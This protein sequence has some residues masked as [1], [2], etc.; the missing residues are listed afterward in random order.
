MLRQRRYEK[1]NAQEAGRCRLCPRKRLRGRILCRIC[2]DKKRVIGR[3]AWQKKYADPLW[4]IK[5]LEQLK[6]AYH[7][8]RG[9][10]YSSSEARK[11]AKGG[12]KPSIG[13]APLNIPIWKEPKSTPREIGIQENGRRYSGFDCPIFGWIG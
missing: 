7:Y 6:A 2:R 3:R 4:R 10:N 11:L 12:I 5:Y 8:Y 1:R 13:H 9:L